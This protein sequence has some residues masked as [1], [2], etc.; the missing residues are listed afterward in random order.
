VGTLTYYTYQADGAL[1]TKHDADGWATST[2]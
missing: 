1:E 2:G